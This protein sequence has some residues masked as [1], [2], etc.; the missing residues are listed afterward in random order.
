MI[1]FCLRSNFRRSTT[2]SSCAIYRF[3]CYWNCF[4]CKLTSMLY[5]MRYLIYNLQN[6]IEG[7]KEGLF[8]SKFL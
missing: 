4:T 6:Q 3:Q 8:A 5:K 1:Y 2:L 7:T